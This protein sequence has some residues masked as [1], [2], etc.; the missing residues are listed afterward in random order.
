MTEFF[1]KSDKLVAE[2]IPAV[3]VPPKDAV[4]HHLLSFRIE[5]EASL[6]ETPF[7]F[8]VQRVVF[9]LPFCAVVFP[10]LRYPPS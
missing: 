10:L 9:F 2:N 4:P 7:F 8:V 5:H 1:L 3:L 6:L